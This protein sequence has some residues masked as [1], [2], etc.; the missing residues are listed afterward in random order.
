MCIHNQEQNNQSTTTFLLEKE[1]EEANTS[2][3][4]DH[5][6]RYICVDMSKLSIWHIVSGLL[7]ALL[8]SSTTN[9][10]S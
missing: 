1:Q 8:Q 10:S 7:L 9:E 5:I 3:Q 6:K 4:I 2:T